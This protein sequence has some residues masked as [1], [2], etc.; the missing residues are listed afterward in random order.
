MRLN[1]VG[2]F[3][4]AATLWCTTRRAFTS[5]TQLP[6]PGNV[7]SSMRLADGIVLA[8][9]LTDHRLRT[10]K[11]NELAIEITD[12]PC[13]PIEPAAAL[14]GAKEMAESVADSGG[15]AGSVEY[16][17]NNRDVRIDLTASYAGPHCLRTVWIYK[18]LVQRKVP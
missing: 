16:S 10:L 15:Y 11:W 2:R 4:K 5:D 12:K 8:R 9:A 6:P 1:C 17:F 7:K 18:N 3:G 14:T 13:F